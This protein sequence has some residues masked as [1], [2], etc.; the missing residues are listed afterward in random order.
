MPRTPANIAQILIVAYETEQSPTWERCQELAKETGLEVKQVSRWFND[1][2]LRGP[3]KQV[4]FTEDQYDGLHQALSKYGS[5]P[6]REILEQ[7][8]R[9]LG[10][11]RQQVQRW[12]SK[13]RTRCDFVARSQRSTAANVE[14]LDKH[15]THSELASEKIRTRHVAHQSLPRKSKESNEKLELKMCHPSQNFHRATSFPKVLTGSSEASTGKQTFTFHRQQ[16]NVCSSESSY[17]A[18][19]Y[20]SH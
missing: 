17:C 6:S 16:S 3:Q 10:L 5:N 11:T 13:R 7:L 18:S 8:T 19:H 1:R 20:L 15:R 2:R 4:G 9:E 12:L 14:L